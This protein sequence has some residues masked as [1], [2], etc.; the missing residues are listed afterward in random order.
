LV[1]VV[2]V[3]ALQTHSVES[4]KCTLK[5]TTLAKRS[6]PLLEV[7]AGGL[8]RESNVATTSF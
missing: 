8:H 2:K 3:C 1:P 6:D 4:Q 7:F 5:K